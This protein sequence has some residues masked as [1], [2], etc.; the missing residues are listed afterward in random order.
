MSYFPILICSLLLVSVGDAQQASC[1]ALPAKTPI[2]VANT[3]QNPN[4]AALAAA[5]NNPDLAVKKQQ[6]AEVLAKLDSDPSVKALG[7][8]NRQLINAVVNG[9]ELSKQRLQMAGQIAASQNNST[10]QNQ[11]AAFLA[12][13]KCIAP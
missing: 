4:R 5:L 7:A 13:S 8:K 11:K 3:G 1:P 6:F 10:Y 2:P 12:S 9:P